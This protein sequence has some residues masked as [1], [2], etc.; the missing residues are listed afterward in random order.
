MNFWD[1]PVLVSCM[2]SYGRVVQGEGFGIL[3]DVGWDQSFSL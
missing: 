1:N 2:K 3:A